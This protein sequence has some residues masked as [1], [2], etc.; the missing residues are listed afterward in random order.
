MVP[1]PAVSTII[2]TATAAA[3]AALLPPWLLVLKQAQ[4]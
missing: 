3:A 2:A 1:G 4:V